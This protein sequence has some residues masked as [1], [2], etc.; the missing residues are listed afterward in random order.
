MP[1][2]IIS[3]STVPATHLT[4]DNVRSHAPQIPLKPADLDRRLRT[5]RTRAYVDAM[6]RLDAGTHHASRASLDAL[7]DAIRQEFPEFQSS[8]LPQGIV[9]RCYLGAPYEV[10][11]L[12]CVGGIVKHYKRQEPLPPNLERARALALHPSYAFVEVY[13]GWLRAVRETGEVTVIT[14]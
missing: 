14:A 4:V 7:L 10:H 12:D 11:T 3:S 6:M 1:R 8:D 5:K 13:A 9:A 2:P